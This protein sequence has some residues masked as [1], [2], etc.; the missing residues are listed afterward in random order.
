[1]MRRDQ[2][3]GEAQAQL[4]LGN[5]ATDLLRARTNL[6]ALVPD[7]PLL[8]PLDDKIRHLRLV[9]ETARHAPRPE[10]RFPCL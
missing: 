7:S 8:P 10:P 1:M 6:Q 4:A 9:Q 3:I 2:A 5:C